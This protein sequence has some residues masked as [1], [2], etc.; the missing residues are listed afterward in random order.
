VYLDAD[1]LYSYLKPE[2]WLK[3]FAENILDKKDKF[4]TSI[5]TV[6]EIEI[7]SLREL[8]STFSLSVLSRLKTLKNLE[9]LPLSIDVL[10]KSVELRKLYGLS[11]FDSIHAATCLLNN[12]EIISSD[13]IFDKVKGLERIDPRNFESFK[14][15][16]DQVYKF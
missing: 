6:I 10:E 12:V 15:E 14:Q 13:S 7:V 5:V 3:P 9:I 11:I 4:I 1:V 16:K 8:G 2:D